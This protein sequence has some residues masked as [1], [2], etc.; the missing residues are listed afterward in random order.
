M[1]TQSSILNFGLQISFKGQHNFM[2]MALCHMDLP[3]FIYRGIF[4]LERSQDRLDMIVFF[5][6]TITY[7][8]HTRVVDVQWNMVPGI[9]IFL[10]LGGLLTMTNHHKGAVEIM[11][12]GIGHGSRRRRL[13]C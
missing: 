6:L 8:K 13:H 3:C 11:Q 5:L 7:Q 4:G 9:A 1:T 12:I 10:L 2:A